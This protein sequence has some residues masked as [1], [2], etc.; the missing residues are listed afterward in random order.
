VI[1]LMFWAL[2]VA[3]AVIHVTAAELWR[4]PSE[5]A[6]AFLLY[7]LTVGLGVAGLIVFVGHALRP[8]ETAARIG[9]PTSP[10]FQYELGAVGLGMAI[11]SL[12]STLIRN[13]HY[14]LGVALSPSIFM[15]LAASNH[16]RD[17][18]AGNLAS[19]NVVT[20]VPDLL[21]PA[22]LAWFLYRVFTLALARGA[23]R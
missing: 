18:L 6:T 15:I 11:A 9:W 20:V 2:A 10:N 7:Q 3:A 4:R 1:F 19:Y 13:R 5:R 12:L 8:A 22:T 21:I 17:A 23:S 14:W 16:L